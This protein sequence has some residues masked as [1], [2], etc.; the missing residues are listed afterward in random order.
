MVILLAIGVM[1]VL[2]LLSIMIASP[3]MST[4]RAPVG[5]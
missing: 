5:N 2:D 1:L 4:S 3:S